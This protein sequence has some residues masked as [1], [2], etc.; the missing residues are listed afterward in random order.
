MGFRAGSTA[1]AVP[2]VP[3]FFQ[4]SSCFCS[5]WPR[6]ALVRHHEG[7]CDERLLIGG[8][9]GNRRPLHRPETSS[10]RVILGHCLGSETPACACRIWVRSVAVN[11]RSPCAVFSET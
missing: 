5:S 11:V 6:S 7:S 3:R 9:A 2:L 8:A 1:V 10:A 4:S